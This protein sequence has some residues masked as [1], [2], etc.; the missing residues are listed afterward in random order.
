M[1]SF[2]MFQV[3]DFWLLFFLLSTSLNIAMHII[4][5]RVYQREKVLLKTGASFLKQVGGDKHHHRPASIPH[6]S[7]AFAANNKTYGP[8]ASDLL[9]KAAASTKGSQTSGDRVR[10]TQALFGNTTFGIYLLSFQ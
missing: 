8:M 9:A 1:F 10:T 7:V 2:T 5:D 6:P 4:I 3:I